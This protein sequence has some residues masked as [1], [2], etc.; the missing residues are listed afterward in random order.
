[1]TVPQI[2]RYL[3][4]D[5]TGVMTL[6]AALD[7]DHANRVADHLARLLALLPL[8]AAA[9]L[10]MRDAAGSPGAPIAALTLERT[11]W[12][13]TSFISD[14][15]VHEDYRGQG[16]G[17]ALLG[18]AMT[19]SRAWGC[20]RIY[21]TTGAANRRAQLFYMRQGFVPEGMRPD[22]AGPGDHEIS[23]FRDL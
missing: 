2:D 19:I 14:L 13:A 6:L 5:R 23:L 8:D 3:P 1:M 18:E 10:V 9:I 22:Y 17:A 20:R 15:I 11:Y 21:L 7:P 16:L 4:E 12:N